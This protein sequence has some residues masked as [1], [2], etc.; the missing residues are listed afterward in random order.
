MNGTHVED[1]NA[2]TSVANFIHSPPQLKPRW[3]WRRRQRYQQ[4]LS[5]VNHW[6]IPTWQ[7]LT[8][9]MLMT[10][11]MSH[12]ESSSSLP[13]PPKT[14]KTTT[15]VWTKTTMTTADEAAMVNA[16]QGLDDRNP[17]RRAHYCGRSSS[18]RICQPP[19]RR[20]RRVGRPGRLLR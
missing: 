2:I 20:R 11:M 5:N 9:S 12:L 7:F 13:Q 6:R 14:A 4:N 1:E 8:W 10:M 16:S 18:R 15:N 17:A 3:L 19:R